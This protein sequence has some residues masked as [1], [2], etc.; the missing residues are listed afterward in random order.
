[1][2]LSVVIP[3]YNEEESIGRLLA[4]V[5]AALGPS[6]MSY[7][8][9]LVDDGSRDK[10]FELLEQHAKVDPT[11]TIVKFRRN[12]GQ[13]AAMQAGFDHARGAMIATID[14]DLQNDPRDI[15]RMVEYLR[16]G[17]D[18]VA[19][20]RADRKDTFLNRRLPSILANW[21]ISWT[22]KVK[23][24]DY[25]CTLK[26]MKSDVAKEMRLYG[27][28]HRFIPVVASWM[29]VSIVEVKVN[30]R[31]RQFGTSKYG[32]G[33][34][35]RVILDLMTVRFI[36][37]YLARPD[38]DLRSCWAAFL[39]SG[40]GH[41]GV[42]AFNRLVYG[43]PLAERPVLLLGILLIVVGV[44][45][46]SLGLVADVLARTYSSPRR[47]HPITC[48][49][50]SEARAKLRLISRWS[51]ARVQWSSCND[52][53]LAHHAAE[54]DSRSISGSRQ[55]PTTR[56][57]S[58]S[59]SSWCRPATANALWT[60]VRGRATRHAGSR[61]AATRHVNRRGAHVSGMHAGG[62]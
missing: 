39:R 49:L 24:H 51:P 57:A 6:G 2:D 17:T 30:H 18:L 46:A 60:S 12:F 53:G 14:A 15:P 1:L 25:G 40:R 22:T 23:L 21:L 8:L 37:S 56:W 42:V 13:T 4:E 19:G 11:L 54:K 43:T 35:V 45:L 50:S 48:A 52:H 9:V 59:P 26:V 29:G 36:Q 33:R 41:V 31:A 7:E 34:T 32:I 16:Q 20:W 10:S 58:R 55:L 5:H 47:S 61:A 44:Q 62:R 38:A 27:E 28:M 3:L